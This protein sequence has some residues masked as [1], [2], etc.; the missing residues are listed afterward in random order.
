MV[1]IIIVA[2]LF[3]LSQR[4]QYLVLRNGTTYEIIARYPIDDTDYFSVGFIHSVNKTPVIDIYEINEDEIFLEETIYYGFG[5]G[6]ETTRNPGETIEYLDDGAMLLGNLHRS[7]PNGGL[8]YI[9]GS[10]SDH[11]MVIG[12]ITED[13]FSVKDYIGI[14]SDALPIVTNS[15][16]HVISLSNLS[17]KQTPVSF[18]SENLFF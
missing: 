15:G 6:V 17:G 1:I 12:D 18:K 4:N 16:L 2:T 8:T 7:I 14:F 10:V 5:A 3:F 11:T 9:V 13:Y